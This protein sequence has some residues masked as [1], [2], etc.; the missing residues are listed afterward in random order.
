MSRHGF[1]VPDGISSAVAANLTAVTSASQPTGQ[2]KVVVKSEKLSPPADGEK[3][4]PATVSN[5]Q[6]EPW[7]KLLFIA[8]R[9]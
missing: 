6:A 8:S 1:T 7:T 5:L 9:K 3:S 4:S 2:R